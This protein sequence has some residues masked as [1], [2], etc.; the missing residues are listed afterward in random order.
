MFIRARQPSQTVLIG[1]RP[2]GID[3]TV[4]QPSYPYTNF[5]VVLIEPEIPNNTGNIGR[6]CVGTYSE[7]HL[8]GPLGFDI[9]D[10]Q[11][12]RAGLDYWPHLLWHRH[13]TF[14]DWW[15]LVKDPSRVFFFSKKASRSLHEVKWQAGDWLVFGKE[16]KG[17][18]DE[19]LR[20]FS[21][22]LVKIPFEGPIRSLNL[23]SAVAVG[24]YE[25]LRQVKSP[26]ILTR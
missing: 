6:T 4:N 17:L 19:L 1:R 12:K 22:Q 14:N 7:L 3:A 2:P 20:D 10:K 13:E 18:S 24:L 21:A 26:A 23:A 16:T 15:Q 25:G 5:H 8:V 9:S 11:L